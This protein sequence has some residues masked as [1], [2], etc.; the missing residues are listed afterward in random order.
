MKRVYSLQI[1]N[2]SWNTS[3]AKDHLNRVII[4]LLEGMGLR[5]R[6]VETEV[7]EQPEEVDQEVGS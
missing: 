2:S 5:P 4:P 1:D 3:R 6:L 7:K